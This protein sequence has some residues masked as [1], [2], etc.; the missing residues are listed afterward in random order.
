M[1]LSVV[2]TLYYSAPY[3][4]EF[5]K[6]IKKSISSVTS[7]YE[8]IF[9]NDG[10]PDEAAQKVLDLY[11]QDDCIVLV[12]LAR[13]YGHHKAMMTGLRHCQGDMI[14]LIDIDLEE[15]PELLELFWKEWQ[16]QPTLDVVYG[17][18]EFRKGGW[19]E[20][21]SGQVYYKILSFLS[22]IDYPP[23]SLVARL[24]TKR[25]VEN[26]TSFP[27]KELELWG[28]FSII[29]FD[30]KAI[31]IKKGHKGST[32]YSLYKKVKLALETLISFSNRPLLLISLLGL[33]IT[34]GSFLGVIFVLI[35]KIAGD[36]GIPGWTTIVISIWLVGGLVIL[37]LG[38]I[39][40]YL[41]KMFSEIKNRPLTIVK[42]LYRK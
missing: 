40:L 37:C 5:Y 15:P 1:K 36:V 39:G 17:V 7:D 42:K 30:Q 18:Q 20:R 27:E 13:N 31:K 8:L 14:F 34:S 9:V 26:A 12:D 33:L 16:V 29:G 32:T 25:Y 24:M 21:V 3:V 10:S 4:D 38:I 35:Q 23:N 22:H 19:F 6:R 28:I 2:T 11:R 41:S